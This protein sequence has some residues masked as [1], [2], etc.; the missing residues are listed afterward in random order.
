MTTSTGNRG[1]V[2]V[3]E[4]FE[5]LRYA[6]P[7]STSGPAL[8]AFAKLGKAIDTLLI[9]GSGGAGPSAL[10]EMTL[11]E[12]VTIGCVRFGKGV[13]LTTLI[14]RARAWYAAA[15]LGQGDLA[16]EM[17]RDGEINSLQRESIW[18]L[19]DLIKH[20]AKIIDVHVRKDARE[21]DIQADWLKWMLRRVLGMADYSERKQACEARGSSISPNISG[22][23]GAGECPH[24]YPGSWADL[25]PETR[26]VHCDKP[27]GVHIAPQAASAAA[28][29]NPPNPILEVTD[30][31]VIAAISTYY[32]DWDKSTNDEDQALTAA[33]T[34]EPGE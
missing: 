12:P 25:G 4:A 21:Y 17:E 24:V 9:S 33:L 14:D 3:R 23:E 7:G 34:Q 2:E 5:A 8:A 6:M 15:G 20:G 16:A 18:Q 11:P 30:E 26:C 31:M 1:L 10:E 28:P 22:G 27:S 32:P 19:H 13:K 29:P